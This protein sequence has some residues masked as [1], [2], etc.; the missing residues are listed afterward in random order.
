MAT[1]VQVE[2]AGA[3]RDLG[4][5]QGAGCRDAIRADARAQGAVLDPGW[6]HFLRRRRSAAVASAFARDLMRHFPHLDERT[7]GLADAAGLARADAVALAAD[8]LARGLSGTACVAGDG[9]VLALETPPAPT[10]LVVRRTSPDG[11]FANLTLARPGLVCAIA[12]VNEHGL[13]GVVEARATTAHTGSC[14][15]PGALLLDQC[16]ERLDTVEKALEW[17]E[18]RPGGGRA[19]LVFRDAAGAA[20][21]IEIDGD[22]RRRV[23]APSGS[24]ADFAGPR[25]SVDPRARVLALDGGGFA[26]ARFTLDR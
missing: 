19:L 16:I 1:L 12:G 11:G 14:Q 26:A 8:E 9:L 10:G 7:R 25:V 20:A 17:C 23:A 4:L 3:P 24:P 6:I 18:R 22:A 21:A 5:D 2:C 15:A 13:A